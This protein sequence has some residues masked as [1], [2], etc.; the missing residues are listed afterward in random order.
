[1]LWVFSTKADGSKTALADRAQV[2]APRLWAKY[3]AKY[4][5][6]TSHDVPLPAAANGRERDGL[7]LLIVC[8]GQTVLHRLFQKFLTLV[9]TPD[10][11]VTVDHKLGRQAVTCTDSSWRRQDRNSEFC[12]SHTQHSALQ[13]QRAPRLPCG[14]HPGSA[15]AA[16]HLMLLTSP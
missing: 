9:G 11:T 5:D 1:M 13:L 10:R 3:A 6:L 7:E 12:P 15:A 8:Q 2:R 16:C 4:N 14:L